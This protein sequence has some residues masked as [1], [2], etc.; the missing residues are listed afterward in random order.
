MIYQLAN[1]PVQKATLNTVAAGFIAAGSGVLLDGLYE[2]NNYLIFGGVVMII[3][4]FAIFFIRE[5]TKQVPNELVEGLTVKVGTA[6]HEKMDKAFVKRE[7]ITKIEFKNFLKGAIKE[8][9]D[10]T[11]GKD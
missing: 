1:Q 6:V 2:Q 9:I 8:V 4:G 7:E 10:E 5:Y 3:A 11:V